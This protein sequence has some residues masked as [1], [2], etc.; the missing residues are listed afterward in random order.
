MKVNFTYNQE[1]DVWSL[2]KFGKGSMNSPI[3]TKEYSLLVDSHGDNPTN[4]DIYLFTKKYIKDN[5]IDIEQ[6]I[7]QS[8]REWDDIAD[9]YQ[10]RA[11]GIFGVSLQKDVTAY[12]SIN[13]RCPYS[14]EDNFFLV[15]ISTKST[16]KTA[17]HELWHFY[18]W[19]KFG[20]EELEKLGPQKYNDIKEALTVLLNIEC[21][22]LFPEGVQDFGY[23][24]HKELRENIVE[25]WKETKDI[26]KL[27]QHLSL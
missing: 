11:E 6:R 9:E 27:W 15:F 18:T 12:V 17:M 23:P 19:Q 2:L 26:E 1:K 10:K 22:D 20:E 3:P 8:Q 14:I 25:F 21:G 24:Q 7:E 16:L 4:K 5:K 13:S